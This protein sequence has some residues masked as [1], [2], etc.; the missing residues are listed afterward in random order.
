MDAHSAGAGGEFLERDDEDSEE[1]YSDGDIRGM[2]E[3]PADTKCP[4]PPKA[5]LMSCPG[6]GRVILRRDATRDT[7]VASAASCAL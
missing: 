5:L 2:L 7:V 6:D 1:N 4:R 3:G